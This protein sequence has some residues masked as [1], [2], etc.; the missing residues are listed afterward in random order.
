VWPIALAQGPPSSGLGRA[1]ARAYSPPVPRFFVT[2]FHRSE[3]KENRALVGSPDHRPTLWS[4]ASSL[5]SA[6]RG[7]PTPDFFCG[8]ACD[9]PNFFG[10][11]CSL[12][13]KN[14]ERYTA[15]FCTVHATPQIQKKETNYFCPPSVSRRRRAAV[16]FRRR[17]SLARHVFCRFL[18]HDC[19]LPLCPH[20]VPST[21]F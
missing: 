15:T 16:R 12:V 10:P 18:C 8:L 2:R 14:W 21:R 4:S 11:S 17:I 13:K 20:S 3:K 1:F 7:R 19:V 6:V 5:A 9:R